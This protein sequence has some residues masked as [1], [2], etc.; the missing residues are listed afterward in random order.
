MLKKIS[1]IFSL[2][3]LI[4]IVIGCNSC[5]QPA[6]V[7][8]LQFSPE[9][10]DVIRDIIQK[11]DGPI[12]ESDLKNI[13]SLNI[14]YVS[15]LTGLEYC[16]ELKQLDVS[17]SEGIDFTPL[18]SLPK[19]TTLTLDVYKTDNV[20]FLAGLNK[21]TD[22]SLEVRNPTMDVDLSGLSSLVNLTS[23]KIDAD[24][25]ID[26]YP[27]ADLSKLTYLDISTN[28]R[29]MT[30]ESSL[31]PLAGLNKLRT[32][33]LEFYQPM[34]L[35]PLS[36]MVNLIELSFINHNEYQTRIPSLSSLSNLISLK[37]YSNRQLDVSYVSD[38]SRLKYLDLSNNQINDLTPL[39]GLTSLTKLNLEN[40]SISD[41]SPL[42]QL[43]NLEVMNLECNQ[44]EDISSLST[45]E[46]LSELYLDNN[47]ITN[48][49][50]L[51]SL[52]KLKTLSL[53]HNDIEDISGLARLS[54]LSSILLGV[55]NIIDI[56]PIYSLSNL[57]TVILDGNP[58]SEESKNMVIE[59]ISSGISVYFWPV[60]IDNGT[61]S[62]ILAGVSDRAKVIFSPELSFHRAFGGATG[63]FFADDPEYVVS[64]F[65]YVGYDV[66]NMVEA[67][68][69][70]NLS[71]TI[72][73][74]S[75]SNASYSID[76]EGK[77]ADYFAGKED[78]SS[79][80]ET[81]KNTDFISI[82][83]PV[84]DP[85]T[86]YV[87][88]YVEYPMMGSVMLFRM[89]NGVLIYIDRFDLWYY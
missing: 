66:D 9:I 54:N 48:V 78:W 7:V 58:L 89:Q 87:M 50:P 14:D 61:M 65:K 16:K 42:S 8:P 75:P 3:P 45:L 44:I 26:L 35:S 40:N 36:S 22:L 86:G 5:V 20:S 76:Y 82:S 59:M 62:N 84:Y 69:A 68:F 4:P 46:N 2:I 47:I 30:S 51:N 79:L 67:L 63:I 15:E 53:S 77:Y 74:L 88:L 81:N 17:I 52:T 25:V 32:L 71:P 60:D 41:L 34:D 29:K 18:N 49:L 28:C 83:R 38:L 31:A 27:L 21:L 6:D 64:V 10:Q 33:I 39:S 12:F 80:Y 85:I 23:L 72:M 11:P 57:K 43:R 55:N 56:S 13:T 24:W 37:I 70:R 19:F 73:T 1:F